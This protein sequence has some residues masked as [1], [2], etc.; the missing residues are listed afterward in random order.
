LRRSPAGWYVA[1]LGARTERYWDGN[2]W[3]GEARQSSSKGPEFP[4]SNSGLFAVPNVPAGSDFL[5]VGGDT[6]D[7]DL[8]DLLLL[9][10]VPPSESVAPVPSVRVAWSQKDPRRYSRKIM[11]VAAMMV[12]LLVV[13]GGILLSQGRGPSASASVASAVASTLNNRTADLSLSGTF[14]TGSAGVSVSGTGTVNF[15][16]NAAQWQMETSLHGHQVTESAVT[17]GD[18]VYLNG[19]F[20]SQFLPGKSWISMNL[21]QVDQVAGASPLLIGGELTTNSPS[22]ILKI[23]GQPANTVTALGPS[24]ID[25]TTVQGYAVHLSQADV[26]SM[27]DRANLPTWVQQSISSSGNVDVSY[28]IFVD[29]TGL[30]YRMTVALAVPVNGQ[31]L[32]GALS[33]DFSNFGTATTIAAPPADQVVSYEALATKF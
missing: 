17:V 23:L 20:V 19:A 3:T 13:G 9:P 18:T 14:G 31:S 2:E 15:T 6:S 4:E 24:I 8:S 22:A 7:P 1:K 5:G 30:L 28:K 25:G 33:M 11:T 12:F 10:G 29:A 21:G 16:Q 32:N 27:I 26:R